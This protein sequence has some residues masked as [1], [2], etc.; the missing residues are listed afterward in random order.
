MNN[1]IQISIQCSVSNLFFLNQIDFSIIEK[2]AN[3]EM[4]FRVIGL[5]G[6]HMNVLSVSMRSNVIFCIYERIKKTFSVFVK[7]KK[8][9]APKCRKHVFC[10]FSSK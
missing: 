4:Y 6:L 8:T 3:I 7:K 2:F 9:K 1:A 5:L 10:D